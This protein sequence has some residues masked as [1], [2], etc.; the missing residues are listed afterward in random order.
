MLVKLYIHRYIG[1]NI[2]KFFV[3]STRKKLRNQLIKKAP[4]SKKTAKNFLK[5]F[6]LFFQ[7]QKM[8]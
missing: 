6:Y 4:N 5:D 3:M 8:C 1:E 7:L 2:F